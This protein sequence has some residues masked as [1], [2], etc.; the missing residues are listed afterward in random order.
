MADALRLFGVIL[1]GA[2]IA[3]GVMI[4]GFLVDEVRAPLAP[5]ETHGWVGLAII[6]S[7]DIAIFLVLPGRELVRIVREFVRTRSAEAPTE[8][9]QA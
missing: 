7:L 9:E 2:M 5:G 6:L 3:F 1:Y 8:T 4:C